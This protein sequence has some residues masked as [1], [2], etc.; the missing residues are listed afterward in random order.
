MCGFSNGIIHDVCGTCNA[1]KFSTFINFYIHCTGIWSLNVIMDWLLL[2]PSIHR[3]TQIHK[4]KNEDKKEK[5][6]EN[7]EYCMNVWMWMT[8]SIRYV[9]C[10]AKISLFF[11][12]FLYR[13]DKYAANCEIAMKYNRYWV[14]MKFMATLIRI[15]MHIYILT[16]TNIIP[17][18]PN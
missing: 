16:S 3:S 6:E 8:K 5:E 4:Y 2:G 13:N 18:N 7:Y 1:Y 15:Y 17:N 11:S 10:H 9:F 12:F 14:L